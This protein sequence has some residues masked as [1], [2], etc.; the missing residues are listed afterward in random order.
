M[1]IKKNINPA[2]E[3]VVY[4]ISNISKMLQVYSEYHRLKGCGYM[5]IAIDS[6]GC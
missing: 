3:G 4:G 2:R 5:K 1:K 6:W